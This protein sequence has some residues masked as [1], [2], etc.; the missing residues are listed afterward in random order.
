M[1]AVECRPLFG[2]LDRTDRAWV[3]G[4]P[5]VFLVDVLVGKLGP[6]PLTPE[7]IAS[8]FRQYSEMLGNLVR[9]Q[10]IGLV[11]LFAADVARVSEQ[12]Q[13]GLLV[14]PISIQITQGLFFGGT[15]RKT[16]Q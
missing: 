3:V 8:F 16:K 5:G 1:G 12:L 9:L 15:T 4:R 7:H 10:P 14:V 13:V 11:K 2:V 6:A